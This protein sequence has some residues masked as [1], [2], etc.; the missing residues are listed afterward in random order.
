MGPVPGQ[1]GE[2]YTGGTVPQQT[3]KIFIF[4]LEFCSKKTEMYL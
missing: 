2:N 3:L 1:I 4:L